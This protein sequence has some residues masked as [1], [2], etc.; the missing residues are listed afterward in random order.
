MQV[1]NR[2]YAWVKVEN[3]PTN[4]IIPISTQKPDIPEL[5]QNK[6]QKIVDLVAHIL[7][8]PTGLITRLTTSDLEIF[9]ASNTEGNPYKR[10]D[11][12]KL[13]IGM[14]CETVAGRRRQMIVSDTN[15]S[16]YWRNNPHAVLGMHSYMGVPIEWED[17]EL[18]GTF[19]ML[20]DKSNQF[21]QEFQDLIFQ[22]KEIIEIDLNYLMLQR[23]LEK[24]LFVKEMQI[25]EAH[26][27]IKNHFNFLISFLRIQSRGMKQDH[28]IQVILK[29]LQN[30]IHTIS[31]IHDE[32]HKSAES[33]DIPLDQYVRRLCDY[34]LE[35]TVDRKIAI[36]YDLEPIVLSPE[37]SVS[38]GFILSELVTN[39]IKHAF[40]ETQ[41]PEIQIKI[42]KID[43]GKLEICY[44]D[45]GVGL[46]ENYSLDQ[47]ESTG[48]ILLRS[49]ILQ[50][51]GDIQTKN[52]NGA[53]YRITLEIK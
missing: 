11:K 17:G 6:W 51:H 13:G 29:E 46:P 28:E 1:Q 26:H 3:E 31:L 20:D 36:K 2:N 10:D 4:L 35:N 16:E 23:Q 27:R 40:A 22:F 41:N 14:F 24:K 48:T 8:V 30:R 33:S 25:R 52:E 5:I 18:F 38:C 47:F 39:S 9:V 34:V 15:D 43:A 19:C 37:N 12:D 49:M 21:S 7:K 50:M 32:L 45:S 44:R 42:R 53:F